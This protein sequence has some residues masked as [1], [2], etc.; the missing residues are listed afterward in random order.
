MN[1]RAVTLT[2]RATILAAS[3]V[4]TAAN[5]QPD[6]RYGGGYQNRGGFRPRSCRRH[7]CPRER[8]RLTLSNGRHV[9]MHDGTVIRPEGASIRDGQRVLA[10]GRV[11]SNGNLR[12]D[13]VSVAARAFGGY[14]NGLDGY[15][16]R[17]PGS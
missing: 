17:Q 5:A 15:G 14:R 3:V 4:P 16:R 1:I 11:A 9:Y 13:I 12:A 8:Y 6:N 2:L 10:R 7:G